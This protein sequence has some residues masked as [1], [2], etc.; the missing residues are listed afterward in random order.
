MTNSDIITTLI[1]CAY[2]VI[3]AII[4]IIISLHTKLPDEVKR[5]ILHAIGFL[6]YGIFMYGYS[7]WM[8]ASIISGVIGACSFI[9]ILLL[10]RFYPKALLFFKEREPGEIKWTILLVY[11]VFAIT[12]VVSWGCLNT[13]LIGIL[14]IMCWGF[15]DMA[16]SIIG[17]L[18]GKHN[19]K[20]GPIKQ[21]TIEGSLACF[22]AITITSII[23]LSIFHFSVPIIILFSL[24]LGLV[25]TL[26][27]AIALNGLDTLFM[28]T[29][30]MLFT[31]I[32]YVL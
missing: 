2:Y 1:L 11:V 26:I 4:G 10:E 12:L 22:I 18:L 9:A 17:K 3:G 28:P 30:I 15:G 24:G 16:A 31:L 19:Y 29:G 23:I 20:L 25:G 6:S 5:K 7:S 14:S 21:K 27:E 8:I 32:L 13:S